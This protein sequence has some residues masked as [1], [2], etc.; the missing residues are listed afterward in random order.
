MQKSLTGIWRFKLDPNESGKA[1]G[2]YQPGYGDRDWERVNV[3]SQWE[4][5]GHRYYTGTAWYRTDFEIPQEMLGKKL[6]IRFHGVDY[7]SDVWF[8]GNYMGPHEGYFNSFEYEIE[9]TPGRH[10]LAV[11]VN[12]PAPRP[13]WKEKNIAKGSLYAFDCKGDP[14]LYTAGIWK[15]VELVSSGDY[16]L[17]SLK[18]NAAPRAAG[19][20]LAQVRVEAFN[21]ASKSQRVTLH[22]HISPKN[23]TGGREIVI[24]ETV[25]LKPGHNELSLEIAIPEPR[26]WWTWDLGDQNLYSIQVDLT[27]SG[28][29]WDSRKASFGIREVTGGPDQDWAIYLN[30]KR[31]FLRGTVYMSNLFMTLMDH[32]TYARDVE[33]M[34]GAN[35]NGALLLAIVEKEEFY[36]LCDEQGLL[37]FQVFPLVWGNWECSAE[38]AD[39]CKP[40]MA[41]MI[42][43][44]YNHPS[45]CIWGCTSEPDLDGL[46]ALARPIFESVK[47]LDH[48]RI[49][50]DSS[51]V[52]GYSVFS[53]ADAV[54][55]Q[56]LCYN[57][58][59]HL[60]DAH[61]GAGMRDTEKRDPLMVTEFGDIGVPDVNSLRRFMNEEDIWPPKW[62]VWR[63]LFNGSMP[64]MVWPVVHQHRLTWLAVDVGERINVFAE[65]IEKFVEITQKWQALVNQNVIESFR[66]K[67]YN[68]CNG[69][70]N[71]HF[72][73]M[74]PAI[75]TALVDYYRVPKLA[76]HAVAQAYRPVHV[77]MGWPAERYE[78][79]W[80]LSRPVYAINDYHREYPGCVVTWSLRDPDGRELCREQRHVD[81]LED[82]V[83]EVGSFEYAFQRSSVRGTY[84]VSLTLTG[85]DGQA[86]SD[87]EYEV[88]VR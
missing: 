85:S 75:T 10:I 41:D 53:P 27:A 23:F 81:L 78:P 83:A 17:K 43:L 21:S 69:L 63:P 73:D 28:E 52:G 7:F 31:L 13:D 30:G 74:Q 34:R 9:N 71:Y 32:T 59:N 70:T 67:K 39:R 57:S 87:N 24:D 45:V 20:A 29:T 22:L 33:L 88:T 19:D 72:V 65:S 38:F 18:V 60:Y 68:H 16:Y 35:M 11:R 48:S 49:L 5:E 15:D 86:L 37:L 50:V 84:T 66:I 44:L 2:Y 79:G 82:S 6:R 4:L 1:L 55:Y 26:L 42:N 40:M 62:P 76:Y 77:M 80:L 64:E 25:T 46:I 3:P 12:A 14:Y 61:F 56:E 36:D 54:R 8:D 51:S 47:N 58:D